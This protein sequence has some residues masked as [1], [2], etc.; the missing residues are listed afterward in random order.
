M[1]Q[2]L[3]NGF[4]NRQ[5]RENLA[6]LLGQQSADLTQGRM[7][8]HLRRLRL[9]GMIERIPKSH[10]YCLTD[11]G[12]RT[13]W[14]FTRTYSRI[15]RPGLGRILPDLSTSTGPLRRCFDQLDQAVK[16]WVDDAKLA[17]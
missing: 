17:A 16:S 4:S 9:H 1:F 7:T 5:L 8:Y 3:P 11:V 2:L 13:A 6:T 15:L 12:L 10:R 14:F